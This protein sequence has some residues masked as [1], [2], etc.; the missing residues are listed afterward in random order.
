MS[1][2]RVAKQFSLL[3]TSSSTMWTRSSRASQKTSFAE[4]KA[5]KDHGQ[6]LHAFR[7]ARENH[8]CGNSR[9]PCL[10]Q[11]E[12]NISP[13]AMKLRSKTLNRL[14]RPRDS[15][16][17]TATSTSASGGTRALR[18]RK[19]GVT[20]FRDYDTETPLD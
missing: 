15:R 20:S 2:G 5:G 11:K 7:R 14:S 16:C 12:S 19:E 3:P 13:M 4:D 6:R 18:R 17:R 9:G 8:A 1:H 10:A